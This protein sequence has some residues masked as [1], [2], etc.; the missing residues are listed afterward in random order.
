MDTSK[1]TKHNIKFWLNKFELYDSREFLF[2]RCEAE[3]YDIKEIAQIINLRKVEERTTEEATEWW[4]HLIHGYSSMGKNDQDKKQIVNAEG[5]F[6]SA[7]GEI[8]C[9]ARYQ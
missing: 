7:V 8:A 6:H 4:H 5:G 9:K 1:S 2:N 3:G